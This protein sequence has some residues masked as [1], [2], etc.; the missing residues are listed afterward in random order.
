MNEDVFSRSKMIAERLK[1]EYKA[2]QGYLALMQGEKKQK[3]V[4]QIF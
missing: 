2:K 4:I 3:I 1:K